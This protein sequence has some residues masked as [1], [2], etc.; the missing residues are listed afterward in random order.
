MAGPRGREARS[1]QKAALL[2][3]VGLLAQ[4]WDPFGRSRRKDAV[5][6]TD[7]LREALEAERRRA[8]ALAAELEETRERF[9]RTVARM[10]DLFWTVEILPDG[11]IELVYVSAD[12]SGVVGKDVRAGIDAVALRQRLSHPDDAE[13][14]AAFTAAMLAAEPA[15][16][17]ERLVGFDGVVRWMWTRGVPRRE[18][19]RLFFDGIT[20]NITERHELDEQRDSLLAR[21][22]AQ[23]VQLEEMHRSRDD[24]IALAGHEL[25]TPLTVVQGYAEH[26]LED[27]AATPEQRQ[28]LEI[29]VR[30]ARS[31]SDLIDDLFDL[32]KLD[33]PLSAVAYASVP[34]E[35]VVLQAVEA[36]EPMA[37]QRDIAFATDTERVQV[38]GDRARLRRMCDNVLDNAVKFSLRG[39]QVRVTLRRE[40][41]TAVLEVTDEGMGIPPDEL[42]HVFERLYRASNAIDESLPG[43]GLGL[44]ITLATAEGHGGTATARSRPEGGAVVSI[45]LPVHEPS[46]EATVR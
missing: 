19:E 39:G 40:D 26:L 44:S 1:A 41:D 16:V 12:A 20:T 15:E 31:M 25:R 22:R 37:D 3:V 5:D 8:E 28:Q 6:R 18:G 46:D 32:A 9:D 35:E 11:E 34:L 14:N 29:V 24:F 43:T 7:D 42:S 13:A 30:R 4:R 2:V 33:A 45:R 27:P 17:E 10:N 23:V 38:I 21:E 36:H